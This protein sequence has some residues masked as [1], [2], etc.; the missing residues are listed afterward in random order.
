VKLK[1]LA[2]LE[3]RGNIMTINMATTEG[4]SCKHS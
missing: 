3:N 2:S 4:R 1:E